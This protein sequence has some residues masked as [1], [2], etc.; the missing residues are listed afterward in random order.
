[1][2]FQRASG[3]LLHPTCLPSPFG[4]GDLGKSAYEFVDFLER[5]GQT[6]WQVLPLGPTGYEHSPYIMNFSTFAGNP[7]LISLEQLADEGLLQADELSPLPNANADRVEFDQVIP[8][9]FNYLELAFKHFQKSLTGH[10]KTQFEQFC[11]EQSWWLDD[12][13][14]FMA[15]LEANDGKPWSQWEKAIARREPDALNAQRQALKERIQFQ[16]FL[17][18]KFFEQWS[19][20]REYANS[21]NIKI[22]GD[23]SIYV[24]HNSSDVWADPEL[25]KLDPQTLE[26]AYIAGV[27]PD[28][29]SETGQLWG[30]PVYAWE[31]SQETQFD[32]W[33]K[34]FKAT[35]QYVDIV[36]VDH[37]RGFEAYWQVPAG[38][39][40]AI[41]GEW[42]PAPGYEFFE[43]LGSRLGKLPVLAE[44]LG[45]IT[46]EVE[47]MRDRFEFPGMR[48]L[49]FAFSEDSKSTH[50]PHHYIQNCVVYSGTHDNDTAL[51]WWANASAHEKEFLATYFGYPNVDAIEEVNWVLIRA[52]LASVADLA[53]I[54]LQDILSL[55]GRARMNDPSTNAGNW[56]WRY[57]SSDL[58]T[59]DV[60][61]RLLTLTR[62]YSR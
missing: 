20:L 50:L 31:R 34:R 16:Q 46:P 41:N 61:D 12:F 25:F 10:Q 58:L 44:D 37:F 17:Q 52:A 47:E 15:L 18:F 9:K 30:N 23:I 6:L 54:P 33:I 59:K 45:I 35:L 7:L 48:I 56:R 49:M 13:V 55:D 3:I 19:K 4:I 38:E 24:C 53:I 2:R 51:G 60:S 43:T 29:F 26:P 32:W 36:R 11:Q 27:P 1:M 14:L 57:R 28:Y 8:Y 62:L 40:T 22:I 5:S 42:I 39:E 21:R